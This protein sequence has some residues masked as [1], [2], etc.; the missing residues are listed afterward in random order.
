M[1]QHILNNEK[2]L[3]NLITKIAIILGFFVLSTVSAHAGG[4]QNKATLKAL[5]NCSK[6]YFSCQHVCRKKDDT[7]AALQCINKKCAKEYNVC[8]ATAINIRKN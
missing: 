2:S 8:R 6:T 5:K 7:K 3:Y 4:G 1:Y